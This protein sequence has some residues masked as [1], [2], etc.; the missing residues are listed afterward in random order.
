MMKKGNA[1]GTHEEEYW[2]WDKVDSW[3]KHSNK[4]SFLGVEFDYGTIKFPPSSYITTIKESSKIRYKYYGTGTE[5][6]GTLYTT[7]ADNTISKASFYNNQSIDETIQY[8]ESGGEL[9][10]FWF[11]W[12]ILTSGCV[13]GFCY[14]DNRW[15][16]DKKQN[17]YKRRYY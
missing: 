12:I 4:I 16:E 3:E 9:I 6:V 1:I 8:L 10:L 5:Y 7:L 11:S 14:L 2:T 15:L 13:I 17:Y